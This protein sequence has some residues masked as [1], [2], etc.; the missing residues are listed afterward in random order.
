MCEHDEEEVCE[1]ELFE[2]ETILDL[3]RQDLIDELR[4][5]NQYEEHINYVDDESV[6]VVLQEIILAEKEHVARLINLINSLDPEQ[7]EKFKLVQ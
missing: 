5:I 2:E 3:L 6:I 4:A 7:K 1:E